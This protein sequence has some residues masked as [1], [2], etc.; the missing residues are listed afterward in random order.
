MMTFWIQVSQPETK[1]P[2]L[3]KLIF[4]INRAYSCRNEIWNNPSYLVKLSAYGSIYWNEEDDY[5]NWKQYTHWHWI[6]QRENGIS[7]NFISKHVPQQ[8]RNRLTNIPSAATTMSEI[9]HMLFI[10]SKWCCVSHSDQFKLCLNKFTAYFYFSI[11]HNF[12]LCFRNMFIRFCFTLIIV[13]LSKL[14][15]TFGCPCICGPFHFWGNFMG[16]TLYP[17]VPCSPEMTV[18][19]KKMVHFTTDLQYL[20]QP[21]VS[22]RCRGHCDHC[23]GQRMLGNQL[24]VHMSLRR[25]LLF[26]EKQNNGHMAS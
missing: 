6:R 4:S 16:C 3:G 21:P 14:Q 8:T 17:E 20:Q 23:K 25:L 26:P 12:P 18:V 22:G 9:L 10:S 1:I 19:K 5:C 11:S 7:L 24:W 2:Y 15:L 13:T